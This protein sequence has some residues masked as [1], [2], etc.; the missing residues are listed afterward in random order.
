MSL[1]SH[2]HQFFLEWAKFF[3]LGMNLWWMPDEG[4]ADQMK[5]TGQLSLKEGG[6]Q[7]HLIHAD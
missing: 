4:L 2:H 7:C 1:S 6:G 5:L 3:E